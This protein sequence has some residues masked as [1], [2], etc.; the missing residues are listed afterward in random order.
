MGLCKDPVTTELNK[1]GYNLVKLPRVGI[2]P[3]DVLGREDGSMEKL[4]SMS[5]VWTSAAPVPPI[6][7]PAAV[8][9]VTG[10]KTSDLDVGIGLKLLADALAGL[11]A[12]LSLP[13]LNLAFKK[14]K[15]VQFKFINVESTS[16]TPF[17]LGKFLANGTLDMS[18]PFVSHYFGNDETQEYIIFDV[19]KSDSISVTAK[20]ESG[21]TV[22][23]DI[24]ALSGALKASVSA[25][26]SSAGASEITF[27]GKVKATFAFKLFEV[28]FENGKWVP[29]G[30][31]PGDGTSF[32]VGEDEVGVG[33]VQPAMIS[34]GRLIRLR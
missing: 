31:A 11:G 28:L 9:G 33:T 7:A 30:V 3:M 23:A 24:G 12:G 26:A 19:L 2:D 29:K 32:A 4:G 27:E 20:T 14:A 15:K 22:E 13:S 8:A 34:P 21:T 25:T 18:N 17:A 1:R 10:E 5:E 16:I 6:G